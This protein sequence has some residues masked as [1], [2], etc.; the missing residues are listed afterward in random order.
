MYSDQIGY[1]DHEFSYTER[2]VTQTFHFHGTY[3]LSLHHMHGELWRLIKLSGRSHSPQLTMHASQTAS[4]VYGRTMCIS[5][6]ILLFPFSS[7]SSSSRV[8]SISPIVARN[9]L[10]QIQL[11]NAECCWCYFWIYL[12]MMYSTYQSRWKLIHKFHMTTKYA[13]FSASFISWWASRPELEVSH[14]LLGCF[15]AS[16]QFLLL[17]FTMHVFQNTKRYV[18]YKILYKKLFK[19]HINLF[20]TF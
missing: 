3:V 17:V 4:Y 2:K 8:Q 5:L 7:S 10:Q 12:Y 14:I 9:K 16:F 15:S 18:F 13:Q 19:I 11:P 20:L 1:D 6:G